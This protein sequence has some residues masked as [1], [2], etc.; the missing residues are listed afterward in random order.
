MQ[1]A[2]SSIAGTHLATQSDSVQQDNMQSQLSLMYLS[3]NQMKVIPI[4]IFL[5]TTPLCTNKEDQLV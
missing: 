2:H 5:K 3:S 1:R 4:A